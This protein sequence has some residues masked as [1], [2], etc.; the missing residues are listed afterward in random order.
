MDKFSR[1]SALLGRKMRLFKSSTHVYLRGLA[2]IRIDGH[3]Q[4]IMSNEADALHQLWLSLDAID[5]LLRCDK[6]VWELKENKGSE[7]FVADKKIRQH[8]CQLL[9]ALP[10]AMSNLQNCEF[11]PAIHAAHE[12]LNKVI[13]E[14]ATHYE[15]IQSINFWQEVAE[16][17]RH[18]SDQI[19]V[20]VEN[21][22]LQSMKERF[23]DH[24]L[25]REIHTWDRKSHENMS[26]AEKHCRNLLE[27]YKQI[28]AIN[29]ELGASSD[30][31]D[32]CDIYKE[33]TK[34]MNRQRHNK[35][36][37]SLVG[38]VIVFCRTPQKGLFASVIFYF[39]GLN[40]NTETMQK[41]SDLWEESSEAQNLCAIN[42]IPKDLDIRIK[43]SRFVRRNKQ[44]CF[45]NAND[46]DIC[47]H[48]I[49]HELALCVSYYSLSRV[50][51]NDPERR[52]ERLFRVSRR[53]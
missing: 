11:H 15:T 6:S 29:L 43:S 52:K 22:M 37:E 39:N 38:Y 28:S 24:E 40:S 42:V 23:F 46:A 19:T 27:K 18:S 4:T 7:I 12:A 21:A 45:L 35:C 8:L 26:K 33:L 53:S 16:P 49:D 51:G 1:A 5:Q 10:R 34:F 9:R 36:F 25:V 48:F 44:I 47:Q 17:C 30:Q 32:H 50:R 3:N 31:L 13:Q 2:T 14:N 20:N 41:L